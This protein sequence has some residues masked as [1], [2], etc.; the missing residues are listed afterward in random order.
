MLD[1]PTS[2]LVIISRASRS[3]LYADP[4]AVL[5][6]S[7]TMDLFGHVPIRRRA[8]S[9]VP[10]RLAGLLVPMSPAISIRPSAVTKT[11]ARVI[12]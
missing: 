3:C 6:S 9:R 5:L 7:A 11:T 10:Y 8:S 1:R 12:G 4:A 2:L